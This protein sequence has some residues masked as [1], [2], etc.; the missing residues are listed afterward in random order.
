MVVYKLINS[1][2]INGMTCFNYINVTI[3]TI[4]CMTNQEFKILC[5]IVNYQSICKFNHN[6]GSW[7]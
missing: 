1:N 3:Y 4:I 7:H 6:N 5:D 2:K